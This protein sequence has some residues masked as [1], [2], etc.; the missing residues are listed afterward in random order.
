MKL[1]GKVAWVVGA[2]SGHPG[3]S[4]RTG[5]RLAIRNDRSPTRPKAAR[6]P[7]TPSPACP[8][9]RSLAAGLRAAADA[10]DDPQPDSAKPIS[11]TP[12]RITK[13]ARARIT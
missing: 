10:G 7:A 6:G 12:E 11:S 1:N 2:S 8:A 13:P 9:R 5:R 4:T 3:R